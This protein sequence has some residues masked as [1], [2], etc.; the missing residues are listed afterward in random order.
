[1][2]PFRFYPHLV[3]LLV[4]AA[5]AGC[6][7]GSII[8]PVPEP[9][10]TNLPHVEEH[11][12]LNLYGV[13][14]PSIPIVTGDMAVISRLWDAHADWEGTPYLFGGTTRAGLDCSAFVQRVFAENFGLGLTRSTDTQVREGQEISVDQ[15]R[16]GDLVFFRTGRRTR[17]V[18]IYLQGGRFLHAS[19]GR[20]VTI[21][22]LSGFYE[23]TFWTARRVL[24]DDLIAGLMP[25]DQTPAGP[26]IRTTRTAGS[27]RT[28]DD[29]DTPR[30]T[31]PPI[32]RGVTATD[33]SGSADSGARRSGW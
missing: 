26:P 17:H 28:E 6:A 32:R 24:N 3:L 8:T 33:L 31:P 10:A 23:R 20:G 1:M 18:G 14:G 22:N 12:E 16:P 2:V 15:L 7:P 4:L 9:I 5:T 11:E 21:D 25:T 30:S 13:P 27:A 29:R 19:S